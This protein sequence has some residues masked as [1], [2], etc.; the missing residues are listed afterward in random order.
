MWRDDG[1]EMLYGLPLEIVEKGK[2]VP[3]GA[4]RTL[5]GPGHPPFQ[6]TWA[7]NNGLSALSLTST[8]GD[9]NPCGTRLTADRGHRPQSVQ[10]QL[11]AVTHSDLPEEL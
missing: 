3:P 1:S 2:A 8:P 10:S 6:A 9:P 7:L 5:P 11:K 4:H